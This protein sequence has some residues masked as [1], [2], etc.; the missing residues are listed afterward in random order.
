MSSW[1]IVEL[2]WLG[3]KIDNVDDIVFSIQK[4]EPTIEVWIPAFSFTEKRKTEKI[5]FFPGYIFI[6]DTINID[7]LR[8]IVSKV[9]FL[10][11]LLLNG[12]D[13]ARITDNEIND[14][15]RKFKDNLKNKFK[16]GQKVLVVKGCWKNL[17]GQITSINEEDESVTIL[18]QMRSVE[19]FINVPIYFVE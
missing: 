19:K 7:R 4:L 8:D 17:D 10:Y 1:Y 15:K 11:R 3:E 6:E 5:V 16:V 14:L 12:K 9:E 18:I 2:S 13:F